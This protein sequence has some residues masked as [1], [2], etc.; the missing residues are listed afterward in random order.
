[1]N[2]EF[3]ELADDIYRRRVLRARAMTPGERLAEALELTDQMLE[4]VKAGMQAMHPEADEAEI[5]RLL[6]QQ[7]ERLR[8]VSDHGIFQPVPVVA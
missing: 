7:R 1:M 6:E 4:M 3:K 5:N 2:P 8:R